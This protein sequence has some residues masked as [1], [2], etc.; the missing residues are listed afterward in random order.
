M[1][2]I[3]THY[4]SCRF[5][6]CLSSGMKPELVCKRKNKSK[7]KHSVK[8]GEVPCN[9]QVT[10]S[11]SITSVTKLNVDHNF[12]NGTVENIIYKL[13]D[14]VFFEHNRGEFQ[15]LSIDV[16]TTMCMDHQV[17]R[18]ISPFPSV[19][20]ARRSNE[21][22]IL[23]FLELFFPNFKPETRQKLQENIRFT[24]TG[25]IRAL[26]MILKFSSLLD[27]IQNMFFTSSKYKKFFDEQ[28]SFTNQMAP[29]DPPPQF[30]GLPPDDE[31]VLYHTLENLKSFVEDEASIRLLFISSLFYPGNVPL[32]D[33]EWSHVQH[34][35]QKAN[36]LASKHI[37]SK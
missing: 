9:V 34:F 32:D 1:K 26:H 11:P 8:G 10:L 13:L 21:M 37:L 25:I 23:K 29:V 24:I 36:I 35:Q 28:L 5:D 2:N 33:E 27:Q 16:F 14:V 31:R 30:G 18:T 4:R 7:R 3:L 15:S 12:E 20:I 22:V 19:E 17:G 6:K